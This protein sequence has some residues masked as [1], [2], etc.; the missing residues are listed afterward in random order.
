MERN[1]SSCNS[2]QVSQHRQFIIVQ[3]KHAGPYPTFCVQPKRSVE[4]ANKSHFSFLSSYS[5]LEKSDACK[6]W[7]FKKLFFFPSP[8]SINYS[9][10]FSSIS[11]V[12]D[13]TWCHTIFPLAQSTLKPRNFPV[14][15]YG[16]PSSGFHGSRIRAS[17][18]LIFV[19]KL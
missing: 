11:F 14:E 18:F 6:I 12:P 19:Y 1:L 7:G 17:V 2:S 8:P 15:I 4:I 16:S 10:Y 5:N 9:L 13:L 3:Y